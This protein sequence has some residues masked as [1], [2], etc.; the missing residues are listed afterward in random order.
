MHRCQNKWKNVLLIWYEYFAQ[1]CEYLL[2]IIDKWIIPFI[3]SHIQW[4]SIQK[5]FIIGQLCLLFLLLTSIFYK[6]ILVYLE[7]AHSTWRK[8]NQSEKHVFHSGTGYYG[9]SPEAINWPFR[10]C[11]SIS[12][13]IFYPLLGY[14]IVRSETRQTC[15]LCTK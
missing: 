4:D 7:N 11:V 8:F 13:S 3:L 10:W 14:K 15:P 5:K 2:F 9:K 12:D 1:M 6:I